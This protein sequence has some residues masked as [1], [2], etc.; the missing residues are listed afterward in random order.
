MVRMPCRV[1]AESL[2]V[3]F[4]VLALVL[5]SAVT[6]GARDIT[7][8]PP[9]DEPTAPLAA[10]DITARAALDTP[11][12]PAPTASPQQTFASFRTLAQR[13]A[14]TLMDAIERSANNDA[15]LDTPELRALK[16]EALDHLAKA[17]STLDLSGHPPASRRTVGISSVLLLE[18]IMDRI[19]LPALDAIPDA[20]AVEA[21]AA[22]NGWT[23][24]QTEIRMTR[25]EGPGGEPRFLFSEDTVRRL[26]EFYARVRDLPRLSAEEIDFYQSFVAGPGFSMPIEFYRHVL[27]FPPWMLR[28]YEEQA[29][30]QWMA[31]GVVTGIAG[32][33]IVLVFRWDGRR[34]LSVNAACRGLQRLIFP[35]FV[36]A[37]LFIYRWLNDDVINLTGNILASVE[38]VV[39]VLQALALATIAALAFN[40]LAMMIIAM[41]R[42]RKESL[43]ASLIRLILRLIGLVVAGS[44]LS[45]GAA[46]IGVPLYGIVA[47]L[48]VGGLA[49]ALAVRPTLENFIGGIIL[50]AD[51][52][53]K[54][55][56]F[57]KFGGMLGTVEMIGLRST[58]IRGLDRTLVT[59][60][61]SD[62]ARMSI[63]NFSRR[64]SNLMHTTIRLR[65]D[66]TQDQVRTV[67]D[68]IATM[69]RG[70]ERVDAESVR[71]CLRNLGDDALEIEIWAYVMCPDWGPF[72]KIQEDLFMNVIG[73]VR[74][75]GTA[76][77]L[78]SHT[79]YLRTDD[80]LDVSSGVSALAD[81]LQ[82]TAPLSPS[83]SPAGTV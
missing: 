5:V 69:L 33:L 77:A 13:A 20:G 30:W 49:L 55:G 9:T 78:P 15:V 62:F 7:N 3:G 46:R 32:L 54:V 56:D 1:P 65:Y 35:L 66:T 8:M 19:A 38:L 29:V 12:A 11:L 26:P 74:E 64:D 41:P 63:T 21:G 25:T 6:A 31:F 51:R 72:L 14:H 53:V 83:R 23:I 80:H 60:Q 73:L 34:A 17:A 24:P 81:G 82:R 45:V 58:K 61:N 57:C 71:V 36:V 44:I 79:T 76:F 47:S 42:V 28:V 40:A 75:S 59:V 39:V 52:P 16:K 27:T 48:G 68:G 22:L 4:F 37:L 10:L 2:A 50:Y 18:E 67:L 43:D 70:D